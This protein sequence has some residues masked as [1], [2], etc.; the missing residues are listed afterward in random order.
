MNK[1]LSS[2][3]S[4][5]GPQEYKNFAGALGAFLQRECPQLGGVLSRQAL[6]K[7]ITDLVNRFYPETS[8]LRQ[9][10]VQW[11]TV[12]KNE[13]ASFGKKIQ[14]T[15]L[16]SVVLDLVRPEDVQERKAGRKLR[17][18]KKEALARLCL[19]AD[20]QGGCLT[21][22]EMAI[23]LKISMPTVTNYARE[24]EAENGKLLPRRGTI[25]DLGPTLTHKREIVE[26]LFLEGKSVEAVM[27]ETHHSPEAI[28]RYVSAFKQVLLCKRKGLSKGEIA[29]AVKM[30]PRLV[31]EYFDLIDYL[32]TKNPRFEN[33]LEDS[34][35]CLLQAGKKAV[36]N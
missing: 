30:T 19:Q 36:M 35:K 18:M 10:Q 33:M 17:E 8:H 27:R 2:S 28:T 31:E 3:S 12:D 9:G 6:V 7:A 32:A 14:D 26:K 13:K 15:K 20:D 25:H 1:H 34:L 4:T 5:Y 16:T 24:W 11:V 21:S 29:F 22:A 23:L